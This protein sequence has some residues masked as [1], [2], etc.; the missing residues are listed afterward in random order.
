MKS[1]FL[2]LKGEK[3]NGDFVDL[4]YKDLKELKIAQNRNGKRQDNQIKA[5]EDFLKKENE[6]KEKTKHIAIQFEMNEY[7]KSNVSTVIAFCLTRVFI[8][9]LNYFTCVHLTKCSRPP[10]CCSHTAVV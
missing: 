9:N 3:Q 2:T 7:L 10:E 6:T 4:V 8:F 5:I 1:T